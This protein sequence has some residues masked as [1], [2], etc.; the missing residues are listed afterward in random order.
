M[1][2]KTVEEEPPVVEEEVT[3]PPTLDNV[4][5]Y[6]IALVVGLMVVGT[7]SFILIKKNREN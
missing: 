5:S 1:V 3:P 6:V 4:I 2:F 7:A